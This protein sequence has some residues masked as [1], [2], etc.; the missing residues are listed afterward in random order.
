METVKIFIIFQFC[1]FIVIKFILSQQYY[2]SRS[3][4]YGKEKMY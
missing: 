4:S 1:N 3:Y 2:N